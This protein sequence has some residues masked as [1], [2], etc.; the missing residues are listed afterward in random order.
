MNIY[1]ISISIFER[2]G[3]FD[4]KIYKVDHQERLAVDKDIVYY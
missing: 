2:L 1:P 3:R 4:L